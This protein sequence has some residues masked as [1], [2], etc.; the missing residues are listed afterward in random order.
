[1]NLTTNFTLEE[2]VH[3]EIFLELGPRAIN[4]LNLNLPSTLEVL[5][6]QL[7]KNLDEG[8]IETVTVNDWSW[9]GK[10]KDSG[11]RRPGVR[12]SR[13][14]TFK[15]I[16]EFA[17]AINAAVSEEEK[18]VLSKQIKTYFHGIGALYSGH[19]FGNCADCKFR[20]HSVRDAYNYIMSHQEFFPYIIRIEDPLYTPS[21]LH[22]EV[23]TYIREGNIDVYKP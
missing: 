12:H 9:G 3:P 4:T 13:N 1:M 7:T 10:Y 19:K 23:S 16:L 17:A 6:Q 5:K 11:Q 20:Y 8:R 14:E 2:L 15:A 22:I 18:K 21:W